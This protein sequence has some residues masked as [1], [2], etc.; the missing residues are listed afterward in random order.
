VPLHEIPADALA[1]LASARRLDPRLVLSTREAAALAP[2]IGRWLA[3]GI[4][5]VRLADT[6]TANLPDHFRSRPAAL[7]AY[8]LRDTPLPAPRRRTPEPAVPHPAVHPF[9][10]CERCDRV[11]RAPAPG[12]C[13]DCREPL[14]ALA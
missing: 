6:L 13:R 14:S 7:L 10:T 11:F 4:D 8:R 1:V 2:A 3:T 9:Q 12:H 5:A